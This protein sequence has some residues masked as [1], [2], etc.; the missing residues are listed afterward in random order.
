M[1]SKST[2]SERTETLPEA[3]AAWRMRDLSTAPVAYLFSDTV[4]DP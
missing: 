3:S 1:L 4:D 2:V